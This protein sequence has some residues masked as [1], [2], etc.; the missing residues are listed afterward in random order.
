[1]FSYP[2][3]SLLNLS[4]GRAYFL[5]WALTGFRSGA[6]AVRPA[7]L[8]V[9]FFTVAVFFAADRAPLGAAGVFG[10]AAF[11]TSAGVARCTRVKRVWSPIV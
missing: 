4:C 6:F 1:M 7:G 5:F 10:P 2:R 3:L 9:F 8:A 11:F